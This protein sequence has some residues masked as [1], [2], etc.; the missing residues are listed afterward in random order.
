MGRCSTF[1]SPPAR[2]P[3]GKNA[4]VITV[5]ALEQ[6]GDRFEPILQSLLASQPTRVVHY[7][8]II[9]YYDEGNTLD[10][11]A[12]GTRIKGAISAASSEPCTGCGMRAASKSSRN[13]VRPRR[14]PP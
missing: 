7:E 4:A 8:P 9:E 10:Y 5:H 13:T 1:W 2:L 6:I 12:T 3:L 14:R 11:L